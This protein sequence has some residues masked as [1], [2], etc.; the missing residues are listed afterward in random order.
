MARC[1]FVYSYSW[2]AFISFLLIWATLYPSPKGRRLHHDLTNSWEDECLQKISRHVWKLKVSK[3]LSSTGMLW[4]CYGQT[5]G[6]TP[7]RWM[8]RLFPKL[9]NRRICK[10][11]HIWPNV[12]TFSNICIFG[13]MYAQRSF[14]TSAHMGRARKADARQGCLGHSRRK[15][16]PWAERMFTLCLKRVDETISYFLT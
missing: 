16:Q 15:N 2:K 1:F 3:A 12:C 10:Y 4:E 14:R 5:Q 7:A 9:S 8:G 13:K 11:L 6:L